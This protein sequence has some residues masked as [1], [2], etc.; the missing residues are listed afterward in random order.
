MARRK[1]NIEVDSRTTAMP[2]EA[3]LC[4]SIN[5]PWQR[6][7]LAKKRW[8]ELLRQGMIEY[9]WVC[10]RCQSRRVDEIELPSFMIIR[11]RIQYS[12]G[13]LMKERGTGRLPRVEARKALFLAEA[14]A[15]LG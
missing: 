2:I 10:F 1:I 7:P 12:E 8:S 14:P 13:Y 9:H 5:H 3:L 6:V 15:S 11:S 4:R